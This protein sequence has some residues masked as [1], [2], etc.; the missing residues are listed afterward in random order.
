MKLH[1]NKVIVGMSGGVDSSVSAALLQ[2]QGYA[3][4]GMFMKN[5][6]ED[7]T[8]ETCSA[9]ADVK[10]AQIVADKLKIKLHLRN[11]ASE[12]WDFVFA[13]FLNEYKIGRTPNPD[14]LCNREI[15]FKT[16][17]ENAQDLNAD[18]MA[19]GHYVRKGFVNDKYQLLKARDNNKDQSYF[20]Y[21]ITQQQLAY[22]LF[23]L[24]EISKPKVRKIAQQLDLT[25][26][27]KKD[28]VGICFIGEKNFQTFL[29]SYL[30]PNPGDII[31]E[32]GGVIGQHTGL[33]YY[34]IGQRQGLGI[35][36]VQDAPPLPWF[37]AAKS[38]ADNKLVAVQA[39]DNPLLLSNSL[40]ASQ[41]NWISAQQPKLPLSCKAKT[42]YRQSD[43][44]CILYQADNNQI[45][46]EFSQPQRAVTPGQSVVF[47]L[48]D[49]CLGGGIIQQTNTLTKTCEFW[50]K[51]YEK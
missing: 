27:D 13:D 26:H 42:R 8:A 17:L 36:G 38:H 29:A 33:M 21:T 7:D 6:E 34:T 19:T 46:V 2:Q 20:L 49:I 9:D 22:T 12:Y 1:N 31:N 51:P 15:K 40:I 50:N 11:F 28:S 48:G 37:V 44:D 10:D 23:P 30:L 47:Y 4:Q 5:W 41:L 18:Y 35:G 3:V 45:K 43:Q 24:G 32:K 14:I 25:V 16:F 39:G